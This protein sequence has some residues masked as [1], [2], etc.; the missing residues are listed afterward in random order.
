MT[1]QGLAHPTLSP[2]NLQVNSQK[3][4]TTLP[5]STDAVLT[6]NPVSKVSGWGRQA[7][8]DEVDGYGGETGE[9]GGIDECVSF[10]V[11]IVV[12]SVVIRETSVAHDGVSEGTYTY[13]SA[14][15]SS[16]NGGFRSDFQVRVWQIDGLGRQ[17]IAAAVITTHA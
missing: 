17:S 12:D 2:T 8:G 9:I 7:Y 15:N 5:D 16:D 3:D 14:T 6:W 1:I 13:D 4:D 10:L 11:Q